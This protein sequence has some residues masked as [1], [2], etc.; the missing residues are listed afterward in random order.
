MEQQGI[1]K[2]YFRKIENIVVLV[3]LEIIEVAK[4]KSLW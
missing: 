3:T 2:E 4:S 1:S